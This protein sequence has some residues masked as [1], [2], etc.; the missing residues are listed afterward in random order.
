MKKEKLE[1]T[2]I[3]NIEK[4]NELLSDKDFE[5]ILLKYN[6][7]DLYA[8]VIR[9]KTILNPENLKINELKVNIFKKDSNYLELTNFLKWKMSRWCIEKDLDAIRYLKDWKIII[10][11]S[12]SKNWKDLIPR[13]AIAFKDGKISEIRWIEDDQNVD[14]FILYELELKL[15]ELWDD[16]FDETLYDVRFLN[17]L[18]NR[19][20]ISNLKWSNFHLTGEELCKLNEIEPYCIRYFWDTKTSN[21]PRVK[22]ILKGRHTQNDIIS[23]Q[24]QIDYDNYYEIKEDENEFSF[25][26]SI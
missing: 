11:S 19:F 21:D 15:K 5:K 14:P 6:F 13:I 17:T 26:W 3:K 9:E 20:K 24:D 16:S 22:E 25:N 7:A 1:E 18:Y 8:F 10:L 12:I 2:E 23:I 4:P